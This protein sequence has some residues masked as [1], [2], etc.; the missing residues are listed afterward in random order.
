MHHMITQLDKLEKRYQELEQLLASNEVISDKEQCN[1]YAKELSD[2]KDVVSLYRE[3]K[4]VANEIEELEVM[5]KEKHERQFL[6]LAKAEERDLKTKQSQLEEQIKQALKGEDKDLNKNMIMEIRPGTGGDEAGLFA[7][8]LY[9]MYSKYAFK[10]KWTLEP[11][12]ANATEAGGFKEIIFELKPARNATHS[13]A[14]RNGDVFSKMKFEGGVHRVQ[15]IPSTESSGRV[16]TSTATVAVMPE[17]EDIDIHLD[18]SDLDWD[19]FRGGGHGG[20]NVNKV[21]SAVRLTHKPTGLIVTCTEERDQSKNREKAE[22][23]LR[24]ILWEQEENRQISQMSAERRA[25][26]GTG[27]RNEKIRTYNF[28]QDRVTDHRLDQNFHNIQKIMEGNLE[29]IILELQKKFT[30]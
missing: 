26:I 1:R 23:K 19:F 8:D 9:R 30:D 11:M 5:L 22:K 20:Q 28:L 18:P 21:S 27:M 13:V 14:G 6:E 24:Q 12:S 29:E 4:R 7:A 2:L 16:H 15:R 10:K 25:Q 3:Y 17:L